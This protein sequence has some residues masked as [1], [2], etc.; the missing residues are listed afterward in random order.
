MND[1]VSLVIENR[2]GVRLYK[3]NVSSVSRAVD[4]QE[5]YP[6]SNLS[7]SAGT[8]PGWTSGFDG[9]RQ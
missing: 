3:S 6:G 7:A 8:H 9:T 5:L 1:F 4:L 2:A